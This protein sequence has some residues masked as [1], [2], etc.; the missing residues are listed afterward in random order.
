MK[1]FLMLAAFL[2]SVC[3][4]ATAETINKKPEWVR[5]IKSEWL[6]ILENVPQEDPCYPLLSAGK[7]EEGKACQEKNGKV[8]TFNVP[9]YFFPKKDSARLGTIRIA[10]IPGYGF[11][12]HFQKTRTKN[13]ISFEPDIYLKDF[14]NTP[15]FH[16]TLLEKEGDWA[17]IPMMAE[18]G[19][20]HTEVFIS[21]GPHS[22][23]LQ[24]SE[25]YLGLDPE[26]VY[27]YE[28]ESIKIVELKER[29]FTYRAEQPADMW[30]EASPA[31]AIE[32]VPLKELK[33]SDLY[34][35]EA[36]L[37]IKPKYMKGC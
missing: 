23:S 17:F 32:E 24:D 34:D 14:G 37:K 31:P 6:G 12:F 5:I 15:Y 20:I 30:C 19:W 7:A 18:R 3:G 8:Q 2:F 13:W 26:K 11:T 33:Y 16:Q 29:T 1:R 10:A 35:D 27:L 28:G 9:I 36:H 22:K 4:A 21:S 25:L